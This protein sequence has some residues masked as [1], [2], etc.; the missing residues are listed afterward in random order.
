MDVIKKTFHPDFPIETTNLSESEI[1]DAIICYCKSKGLK[2]PFAEQ[3]I[4]KTAKAKAKKTKKEKNPNR[5]RNHR[6]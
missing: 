4:N 5:M 6:N 1:M 2:P 3:Q